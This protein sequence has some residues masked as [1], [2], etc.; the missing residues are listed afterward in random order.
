M[1]DDEFRALVLRATWQDVADEIA[2]WF[3]PTPNPRNGV[4]Q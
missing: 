1:W 2:T 3:E 4:H